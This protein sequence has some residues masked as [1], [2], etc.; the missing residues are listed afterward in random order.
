MQ[1][2]CLRGLSECINEAK[3]FYDQAKAANNLNL[4]PALFRRTVYCV[5]VRYGDE[6]DFDFMSNQL[7]IQNDKNNKT[8]IIYGLS[9]SRELS[10]LSKLVHLVNTTTNDIDLLL[11][12]LRNIAIRANGNSY[13]WSFTKVN[14]NKLY[15]R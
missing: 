4:V 15:E 14:W 8:E 3:K 5:G 12:A 13:A 10:Q 9:C 11:T 2:A 1:F 6:S 7:S